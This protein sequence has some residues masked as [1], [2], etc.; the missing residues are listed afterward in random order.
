M[1]PVFAVASDVA[2]GKGRDYYGLFRSTD[3]SGPAPPEE[4]LTHGNVPSRGRRSHR[5]DNPNTWLT[6]CPAESSPPACTCPAA[7][8]LADSRGNR[9]GSN[10]AEKARSL[11]AHHVRVGTVRLTQT[12][13]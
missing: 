3:A 11:L 13:P 2:V 5:F 6:R 4:T 12:E 1:H 8:A 10:V 7:K 9:V